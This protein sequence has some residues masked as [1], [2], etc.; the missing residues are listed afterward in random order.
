MTINW[1]KVTHAGWT[2]D[3]LATGMNVMGV[4][5]FKNGRHIARKDAELLWA[6]YWHKMDRIFFGHAA[7]KGYGIERRC[8]TETGNDG[9]NLHLHFAALAP[10]ATL[11]FCAI[12]NAVWVN[13]HRQTA[14]Y[15]TNWITPLLY[16]EHGAAYT[17]KSSKT[18]VIDEA[19][20]RHTWRNAQAQATLGFNTEAQIKRITNAIEFNELEQAHEWVNVH[21]VQVKRNFEARQ[22]H[23][24]AY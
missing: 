7:D 22:T 6:T 13:M 1:S 10:V 14:P 21:I 5:K 4:L 16:G 9:K 2:K 8:F 12:A 11:P 3:I 24:Q 19:G 15:A 18:H 20:L 23:G 17:A